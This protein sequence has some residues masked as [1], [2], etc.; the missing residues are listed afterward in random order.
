MKIKAI[1][2]IVLLAVIAT[3]IGGWA[4]K[5]FGPAKA[6]AIGGDSKTTGAASRPDGVSVIN[7]HGQKRCCTCLGIGNLTQKTL[8]Q[9]FAAEEK[10]G[11][12]HWDQINYDEPANAHFLN[13][14][15]LVSSTVVVTRWNNGK[16]EKWNR[17]DAVWDHVGD[18]P[19]FRSY[20]A[21]GVR[22]L[23]IQP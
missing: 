19:T 9:D 6:V 17:L 7:F 4:L 1:T 14:Y 23:L 3:S 8:D 20:I 22:D 18:E 11:K 10:A 5:E 13:D 15:G 21:Q 2:R 16:E 12:V